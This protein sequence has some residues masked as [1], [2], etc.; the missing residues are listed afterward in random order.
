MISGENGNSAEVR[1]LVA[2]DSFTL[3]PLGID[4]SLC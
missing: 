3:R 2:Y 4:F 1:I